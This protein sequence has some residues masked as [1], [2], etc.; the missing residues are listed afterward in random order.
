V[1][2]DDKWRQRGKLM[3]ARQT[4]ENLITSQGKRAYNFEVTTH[5]RKTMKLVVGSK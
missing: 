4:A 1:I 2:G 5:R 3:I